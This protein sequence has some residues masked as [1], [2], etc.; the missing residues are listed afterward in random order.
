MAV[1]S[2][3][4]SPTGRRAGAALRRLWPRTAKRAQAGP[5]AAKLAILQRNM[6]F[7]QT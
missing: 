7:M 1:P 4:F 6:L 3:W 2:G 5:L